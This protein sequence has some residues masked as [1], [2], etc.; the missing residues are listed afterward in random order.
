[1]GRPLTTGMPPKNET[2]CANAPRVRK[3]RI[4]GAGVRRFLDL[5]TTHLPR[6][7]LDQL[8]SF[9]IAYPTR[10]GALMRVPTDPRAEAEAAG[11]AGIPPEV[12]AVQLRARSLGCDYVLFDRDAEVD[13]SLPTWGDR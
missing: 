7:V 6:S 12:L 8:N 5:S 1:M 4:I 9:V 3:R 13:A 11:T 2:A 10:D